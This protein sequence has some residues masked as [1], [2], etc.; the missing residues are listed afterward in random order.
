L[1]ENARLRILRLS[2][3]RLGGRGAELLAV[4]LGHSTALTRLD[5]AHSDLGPEGAAEQAGTPKSNKFLQ[6]MCLDLVQRNDPQGAVTQAQSLEQ[7]P[8][9]FLGLGINR[10]EN[11]GAVALSAVLAA[12]AHLQQLWL[13]DKPCR[14]L[15]DQAPLQSGTMPGL[16][17]CQA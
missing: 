3:N 10:I 9:Q 17:R 12:A 7:T 6:L 8:L 16:E 4:A 15:S 14:T 5:L 2:G 1:S 13:Q 11:Q